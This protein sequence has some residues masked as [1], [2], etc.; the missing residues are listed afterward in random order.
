MRRLFAVPICLFATA[1]IGCGGGISKEDAK[2]MYTSAVDKWAKEYEKAEDKGKVKGFDKYLD[3]E[4]KANGADNWAD[5]CTKAAQS[6]GATEWGKFVTELGEIHKKRMDELTKAMT[7][8]AED[9]AK[10]DRNEAL[11]GFHF[12]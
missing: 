7:K 6:M 9:D 5:Y 1:L 2:K 4:S 12:S 10:K 11:D 8:K 3:E